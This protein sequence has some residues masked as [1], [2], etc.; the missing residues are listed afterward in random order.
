[1]LRSQPFIIHV[2]IG[3]LDLRVVHRI[4]ELYQ[5]LDPVVINRG[6][7]LLLYPDSKCEV[8]VSVRIRCF[9][10]INLADAESRALRHAAHF[11]SRWRWSS[12]SWSRSAG[13]SC[14]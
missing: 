14:A 12:C 11:T 5:N 6:I 8:L 3:Q 9:R 13:L 10:R 4:I 2:G 1:M 7:A